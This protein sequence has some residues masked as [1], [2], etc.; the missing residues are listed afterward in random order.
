M[1]GTRWI[2]VKVAAAVAAGVVASTVA[3]GPA[4]AAMVRWQLHNS[5]AAGGVEYAFSWPDIPSS[6]QPVIGDWNGNTTDTVGVACP[7]DDV[8]TWAMQNQHDNSGTDAQFRWG[9]NGCLPLVGDWNGNG[10]TTPG[11]VCIS[12]SGWRW[13]LSNVNST[14]GVDYD[15]GWGSSNGCWPIVG[16]WDGNGTTTV[17]TVCP[18][19]DG[20][21]RWIMTNHNA[22]SGIAHDFGWGTTANCHPQVGDWNGDGTT[23]VGLA[24]RAD[25]VWRW[26]MTN[27]NAASGV[28]YDFRWGTTNQRPITGDWNGDGT[29]TVGLSTLQPPPPPNVPLPPSGSDLCARVG[30]EAGF[31]GDRLVVAVAVGLAESSCRPNATN[32][33]GPTSGC[34]NGSID[35]GLWQ[36]NSCYHSEV[37]VTCAFDPRCNAREA[38]RISSGGTNWQPWATY[39]N[40]RYQS[41]LDEARAAVNRL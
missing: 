8:W 38:Y 34:P 5:N 32:S 27:H 31:R 23:T 9:S 36:I 1:R 20:G 3:A 12:G 30:Y 13:R 14:N 39:N 25:D 7:V 19:A 6:C 15:F 35:R 4:Q 22:A 21:W 33:N 29:T 41:F 26:R 16:D 40:G 11:I 18:K 28:N 37:G 17:G 10:T 24:C 2:A